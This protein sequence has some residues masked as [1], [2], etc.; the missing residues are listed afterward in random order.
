MTVGRLATSGVDMHSA[1]QNL[2]WGSGVHMPTAVQG[3]CVALAI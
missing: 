3:R 2:R 1:M